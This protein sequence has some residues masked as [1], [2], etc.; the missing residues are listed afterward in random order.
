MMGVDR[1]WNGVL[2]DCVGSSGDGLLDDEP[3]MRGLSVDCLPRK[4]GATSWRGGPEVPE[5]FW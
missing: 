1:L 2:G 5:T 4:G 3:M